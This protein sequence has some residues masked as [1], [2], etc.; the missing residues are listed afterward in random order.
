MSDDNL[1][2][3]WQ[4]NVFGHYVLVRPLPRF[5]LSILKLELMHSS[6]AQVRSLQKSLSACAS[7]TCLGPARVL[8]MSSL[9]A[10]PQHYDSSD[11]QL[12]Q[13]IHSYEGSKYQMDLIG[14]ELDRRAI[15]AS[16]SEGKKLPEV[17]HFV[18]HP[19]VVY[20]SI[21]AVLLG[22][23]LH[24]VK[25]WV[26]YLVRIMSFF[27]CV[28]TGGRYGLLTSVVLGLD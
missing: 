20:T 22:A 15:T 8:W 16:Q 11:W 17:R 2:W 13:S 23:F 3:V 25:E 21:D 5:S 27:C 26:F 14:S 19:G 24:K 6:H 4:C 12:T 1:G 9:E 18:V 7:S 28:V 10:N